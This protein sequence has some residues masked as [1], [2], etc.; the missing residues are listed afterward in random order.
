MCRLITPCQGKSKDANEKK[1]CKDEES[2]KEDEEAKQAQQRKQ[3]EKRQKEIEK[4]FKPEVRKFA[5]W[6]VYVNLGHQ[7]VSEGTLAFA[8]LTSCRLSCWRK[9]APRKEVASKISLET[10]MHV[11]ELQPPSRC[12]PWLLLV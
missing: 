2:G 9:H 3:E 5:L 12:R 8:H 7:H 4:D 11:E 1:D 10:F 6:S